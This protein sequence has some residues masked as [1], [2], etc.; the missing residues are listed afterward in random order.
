MDY[1]KETRSAY[2]EVTRAKRY[3]KQYK[4]RI[5]WARFAMWRERL[6][7]RTALRRCNLARMDR[8]LDIPCGTG[9]LGDVLSKTSCF[10][11]ACDI[12][13]E[14]MDVAREDY[15]GKTFGGFVQ[16]DILKT[17]FTG[18]T[19]CCVI[20]IGFM[21]RIPA[22][23]RKQSLEEISSISSRFII[24][25]YSIDSAFQRSK[26]WIIKKVW[27]TYKAAPS[28]ASLQKI[29]EEFN[30]CGLVVREIFKVIFLL[31][32]EVVFLLEKCP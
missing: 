18:G 9:V 32:S 17:P 30:S 21:H 3:K 22:D 10:I 13:R 7:V 5:T 2:R 25:S 24:I 14:M 8:I 31:S 16:T 12:S 4:E 29:L 6:I 26:S 1:E 19:F 20:T 23:I 15:K 27:P 11:V 28:P